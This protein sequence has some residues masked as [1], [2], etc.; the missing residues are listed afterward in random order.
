MPHFSVN[1]LFLRTI[2]ACSLNW[3]ELNLFQESR[4]RLAL[5][6]NLLCKRNTLRTGPVALTKAGLPFSERKSNALSIY[7]LACPS[8][9]FLKTP[10]RIYSFTEHHKF[11]LR[12]VTEN[13][14]GI[15]L[16]PADSEKTFSQIDQWLTQCIQQH[17]LCRINISNIDATHSQPRT[18]SL[19]R[20]IE[21]NPSTEPPTLRLV[22]LSD[23]LPRYLT[24][25]HRWGSS[26]PFQTTIGNFESH[27]NSIPF[28]ELPKTFQDAI[29]LAKSL[30]VHHLWIDSICIVQDDPEDWL[31][32]SKQ[33]G[34]IYEM[35]H[36]TLAAID[37][38]INPG[39][40]EGLFLDRDMLP[41]K[42]SLESTYHHKYDEVVNDP[43]QHGLVSY[44]LRG[45][46][47]NTQE[48]STSEWEKSMYRLV[49]EF[50]TFNQSVEVSEWNNRAWIFQ[51]RMLSSRI[52]FF[53]KEQLF[54]EC[55]ECAVAEH[56]GDNYVSTAES[57]ESDLNSAVRLH[58]TLRVENESHKY[59]KSVAEHH[60]YGN[61]FFDSWLE[62]LKFSV[63]WRL[64][65]Q[66]SHCQLTLTPDKWFAIAGL[67]AVLQSKF[68]SN[69]HAGI[70]DQAIGAGLLWQARNQA[71]VP[72]DG[73]ETPSWSWLGMEGA[74]R[75]LYDEESYTGHI[76][77]IKSLATDASFTMSDVE[78]EPGTIRLV[79]SLDLSCPSR[80]ARLSSIQFKDF[81]FS[82]ST[83]R[84][85]RDPR[86]WKFF[87]D[88]SHGKSQLE[89]TR[90][91][92]FFDLPP[93]T[94]LL[95]EEDGRIVGWAVMD[96]DVPVESNVI[97][98]SIL[99][100]VLNDYRTAEQHIVECIILTRISPDQNIYR[101]IGRGRIV[102][103][104]WL[105][106]CTVDSF[107]II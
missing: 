104:G 20:F 67:C 71:L 45:Q 77:K 83:G 33:M 3:I 78:K 44:K 29:K 41:I 18:Q 13:T 74:V 46:L 8:S 68:R 53:T 103:S 25:S 23:E 66:Y 76:H 32:Q 4:P 106:D 5:M 64:V 17:T 94:R 107:H 26:Q 99:L 51:E 38:R 101:R 1:S 40:D 59:V 39:H 2:K 98:A 92:R 21:L 81:L 24:L 16:A 91:Y 69:I 10:V 61:S 93:R 11:S 75:Y 58:H 54:W 63:W 48:V 86:A 6:I 89:L 36:C 27:K 62:H 65:E 49:P 14:T 57:D 12:S 55:A 28:A 47:V 84:H 87:H 37:A 34:S 96:S 56:G 43:Q 35:S 30:N 60:Q 95:S 73:F 100:R 90:E 19:V 50:A 7:S 9:C 72:Y 52:I 42:V 105:N 31:S 97:C 80:S 88:V 82:E 22:E 15:S 102:E 79:G 85:D 70:W